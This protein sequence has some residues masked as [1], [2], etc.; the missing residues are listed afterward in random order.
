MSLINIRGN[1]YYIKGGTNSGL[2]LFKD[3]TAIIIDP[4]LPGL[5][6]RKIIKELKEDSIKISYIINTH[7]HDDHYGACKEYKLENKNIK[8][9]SSKYAKLYIENPEL[10]SKYIIGGKS[11]KFLDEFFKRSN[12]SNLYIDEE[13]TLG[14]AI[15]NKEVFEIIEFKGHTP[16]SIGVMTKDKVL[17]VGDLLVSEEMLNKYDFLFVFDIKDYIESLN[18]LKTINFE[19]M[20]L[21]HG[22]N[23]IN[24]DDSYKLIEKHEKAINNY[25]NQ[26]KDDLKEP[27]GI[28]A[29]LKNIIVR[30]NL[31]CNYKE[32][33]FYKSSLVSIISYLCD[34]DEVS[35]TIQDGELLYYIQKNQIMIK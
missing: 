10:F 29:L 22:K 14:K 30:N 34:L 24:K 32:F 3:N 20:V 4:G 33:Y 25:I 23:I 19:Y 28:E 16:G 9:L 21:G 35:Y 18:K 8:I 6:P 27:M 13:L 26:I 11:N 15:I 2:Y 17:F 12:Q 31:H 1:T 5:R 7:E